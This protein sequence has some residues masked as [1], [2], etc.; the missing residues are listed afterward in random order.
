MKKYSL[1]EHIIFRLCHYIA[2]VLLYALLGSLRI[3][4]LYEEHRKKI[5]SKHP[6][7]IYAFWHNQMLLFAYTHRK[8]NVH[9]LISEHKDG[10]YG[11]QIVSGMGYGTYRGSSTRG[12]IKALLNILRSYKQ[13]PTDLGFTVDGPRGPKYKCKMGALYLA[14]LTGL[15]IIP[16][17]NNIRDKITLNSWD[18][19]R[20]PL[21][22]SY[23]IA[24]WGEPLYIPRKTSKEELEKYRIELEKRLIAL[25]EEVDNYF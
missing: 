17:A 13:N 10:E 2:P 23:A 18:N 11:A 21:P 15:P 4:W 16:A 1:I 14:Q 20:I 7:V 6:K 9:L 5:Q 8:Q 19:Y 3:R 25:T 12:G 24:A 22:F